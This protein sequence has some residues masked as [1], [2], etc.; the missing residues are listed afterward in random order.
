MAVAGGSPKQAAALFGAAEIARWAGGYVRDRVDQA[1][2]DQDLL[3]TKGALSPT[4]FDQA[5]A[6]GASM[7]L[8]EVI[9][10]AV[11]EGAGIEAVVRLLRTN[12]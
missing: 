12:P 8:D 4:E 6:A 2:V 5:W 7:T 1:E 9:A 11:T 3:A 10:M